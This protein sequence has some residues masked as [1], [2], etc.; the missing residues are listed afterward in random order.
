[1]GGNTSWINN[2]IFLPQPYYAGLPFEVN[3]GKI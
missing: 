3:L 2:F 1:M